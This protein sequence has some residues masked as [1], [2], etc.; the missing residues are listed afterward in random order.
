MSFAGLLSLLCLILSSVI[1]LAQNDPTAPSVPKSC[2]VTKQAEH[3]FVPPAPHPATP[4]QGDFWVGTERLWTA[5]PITGMWSGLPHYT[6]DDTTFRQKLAFWRKD[7][8]PH[9]EPQP[10]LT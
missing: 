4:P 5:L 3:P 1:S 8:H 9:S 2:P 10:N 6:P 7:Y